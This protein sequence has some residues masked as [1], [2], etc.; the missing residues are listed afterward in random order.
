MVRVAVIGAGSWGTTFAALRCANGPT[1]LW[2]RRPA[3]AA[4]VEGAHTNSAYLPGVRLPPALRATASLREAVSQADAVAVAVPTHGFRTV[5][6]RLAGHLPAGIPVVSLAKGLEEQ[7][8]KRMTEVIAEVLPG[9]PAGVLT[10]PNLAGEIV[11]GQ[12]AASVLAMADEAAA[13]DLQP[14]FGTDAFRVY[15]NGDVIGCEVA[16]AFK[17][18]VAIAAGMVDGMGLGDNAKAA[19]VTRGLAELTRLSSALGGDPRT[20]AG[21]AGLGD[22]VATCSSAKSRNHQVGVQLGLGRPLAEIVAGTDMIAEGVKSAPV[23]CELGDDLGVEV[24]IAEQTLA[25]CQ[26]HRSPGDALAAL[27]HRRPRPELHGLA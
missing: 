14:A 22:L 12:P 16:G 1:T 19:I 4:E 20:C 10:G 18:V 23:V 11:A 6:A 8:A 9:H 15:T 24:P 21:L 5:L 7:T 27:M 3:L 2:A 17:N 25:V 13:R 26:G